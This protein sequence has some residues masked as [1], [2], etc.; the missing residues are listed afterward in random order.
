MFNLSVL[1][2]DAFMKAVKEDADWELVFGGKVYRPS[3][4]R[5]LWERIMRATYAYRRAR[6]DLHRP[7]QPRNNLT[8]A[9][10]ST[11]PT[12]AASS[13]C[14]PMA[15]AC[16]ARSI[17]RAGRSIRSRRGA[18]RRR[19]RWPAGAVAVRMLD[20]VID[21]SRF[22]LPQQEQEAKAKRRIGLGVTGLADALILCGVR[23]GSPEAVS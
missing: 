14:R 1:V 20:N 10:R 8:I 12:R 21:V 16:W 13:R 23:Y 7:H 18:A 15:P 6:R 5:E 19:P 2:T 4:A 22:P 3:K 9:R 11:R 17:W